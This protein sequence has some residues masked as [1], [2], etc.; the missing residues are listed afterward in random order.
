MP[1]LRAGV[2]RGVPAGLTRVLQVQFHHA[3]G[4]TLDVLNIRGNAAGY[5]PV[6]DAEPMFNCDDDP[7]TLPQ[8]K[9]PLNVLTHVLQ[10]RP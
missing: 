7:R 3:G 9:S 6:I 8:L 4:K 2:E 5:I 10:V 1:A